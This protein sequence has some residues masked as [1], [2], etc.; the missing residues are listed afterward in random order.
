V[1]YRRARLCIASSRAVGEGFRKLGV[2]N[3][4]II[5]NGVDLNLFT[6][7]SEPPSSRVFTILSVGRLEKVKGHRYLIDAFAQIKK[8]M[9]QAKLIFVGDG[10]ERE[11]LEKQVSDLGLSDAEFI[12]EVPHRELPSW[13]HGADVFVMPSLSEGFGICAIEAMAS[14]V[15]VVA[16]GV[17]GLLDIIENGQTGLLVAPKDSK[18]LAGAVCLLLRDKNLYHHIII[19]AKESIKKYNWG[20]VSLRVSGIYRTLI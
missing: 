8:E 11:N 15:P 19:R 6:N 1:L 13:Y 7:K 16:S 14:G 12:G 3:I 4:Q 5:P 9:P 18:S 10:S 20:D 2:K 17:G